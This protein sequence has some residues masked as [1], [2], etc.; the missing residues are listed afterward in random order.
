MADTEKLMGG[1][2]RK[3]GARKKRKTERKSRPAKI[4]V[5]SQT[6]LISSSLESRRGGG[7]SSGENGTNCE[8]R[9]L[10]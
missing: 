1:K 5:L 2:E 10:T 3:R 4:L 8:N 6:G 7:G 9:C